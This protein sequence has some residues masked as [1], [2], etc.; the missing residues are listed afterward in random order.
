VADPLTAL[1][2]QY[3]VVKDSEAALEVER[4]RFYAMI[5]EARAQGVSLGAISL[6]LQ[7]SR[8]R[9]S[10]LARMG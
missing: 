5:K 10:Q 4:Q 8:T 7:I 3:A 2:K 1:E 9:V 6:R